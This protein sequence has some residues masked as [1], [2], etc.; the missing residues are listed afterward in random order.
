MVA[1]IQTMSRSARKPR[2][3]MQEEFKPL[4]AGGIRRHQSGPT[5]YSDLITLEPKEPF[6]MCTLERVN[7]RPFGYGKIFDYLPLHLFMI[8]LWVNTE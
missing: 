5:Q 1:T 6:I 7:I 4:S 2:S 3:L 8:A